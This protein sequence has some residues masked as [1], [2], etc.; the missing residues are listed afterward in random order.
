MLVCAD[1][2]STR[3]F[4]PQ[5]LGIQPMWLSL[6]NPF[7]AEVGTG[8]FWVTSKAGQP[9]WEHFAPCDWKTRWIPKWWDVHP[10][11]KEAAAVAGSIAALVQDALD[12]V[13]GSW[14]AWQAL[15][16]RSVC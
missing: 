15:T 13:C 10:S 9:S 11:P 16:C 2:G 1:P 7:Q 3:R 14:K 6:E 12:D 5:F 8:T 4:N